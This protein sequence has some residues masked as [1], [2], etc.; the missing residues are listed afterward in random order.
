MRM[1]DTELR[2]KLQR[3]IDLAD[4]LDSLLAE[5]ASTPQCATADNSFDS[6]ATVRVSI[7]ELREAAGISIYD[8]PVVTACGDQGHDLPPIT[9][10]GDPVPRGWDKI[11]AGATP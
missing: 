11:E 10:S 8:A 1:S 3:C 9:G 4:E 7:A 2:S 5:C 6:V